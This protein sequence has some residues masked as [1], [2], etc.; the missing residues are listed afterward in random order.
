[1]IFF[2]NFSKRFI[3]SIIYY[4]KN[5]I[6]KKGKYVDNNFVYCYI[7]SKLENLNKGVFIIDS[8]NYLRVK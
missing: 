4:N 1:M 7:Y 6:G 3:E 8:F 5:S 2:L